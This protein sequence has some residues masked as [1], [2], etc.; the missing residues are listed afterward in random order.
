M[1]AVR[2]K[3]CLLWCIAFSYEVVKNQHFQSTLG[4]AGGGHKKEY[5]CVRF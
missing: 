4:R 1:V 3:K 5:S 2:L